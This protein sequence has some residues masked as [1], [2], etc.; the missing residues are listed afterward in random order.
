[1]N[2]R[3]K[4]LKNDMDDTVL[5]PL[6]FDEAN[7]EAVRKSF[8]TVQKAPKAKR[9]PLVASACLTVLL[10]SGLSYGMLTHV[11]AP[12]PE[13]LDTEPQTESAG[14]AFTSSKQES[15][16]TFTK[17]QLLVKMLNAIDYFDTATGAYTT[18]DVFYD[19]SVSKTSVTYKYSNS[20]V[21]GGYENVVN[22]IDENNPHAER[23]EYA[24]YYEG[25]T[26]WMVDVDAGTYQQ[27]PYT[28]Q[29]KKEPVQAE[30]VFAIPLHRIYDEQA[31]YRERP[32]VRGNLF[33]YEFIAKYLRNVDAWDIERQNVSFL[34]H[35]TIVIAGDI[36]AATR[37]SNPMQPNEYSFRL[38]VDKDTGIIMDREIYNEA[39][40]VVSAITMT[41]LDIN[42]HYPKETFIPELDDLEKKQ[43]RTYI[44]GNSKEGDIT[45]LEHADTVPSA[46]EHVMNEQRE[47]IPYFYAF[48][49]EQVTPFSATIE[50][51]KGQLHAYVVYTHAEQQYIYTR[52][53]PKD[54]VVRTTGEFDRPLETE[55]APVTQSGL[56]WRVFTVSGTP[57][58]YATAKQDDIVYEVVAEGVDVQQLTELLAH[59]QQ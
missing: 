53:Y 16:E 59:F 24:Y 21:V 29:P 50:A 8:H 10:L 9:F 20:D 58:L 3:L 33:N 43:E 18:Y 22:E 13:T 41:S 27:Q 12:D 23:S 32:P 45:V 14:I 47:T 49:D 51:Y 40:D 56:Q 11:A 55:L 25:D 4:N 44:T 1:M 36:D 17:E 2:D 46:V 35:N 5:K 15:T 34:Q 6:Q 31:L 42:A 30:D 19:G 7:K 54:T 57:N 26:F 39:G 28:L 38:W 37:E 48:D 52:M